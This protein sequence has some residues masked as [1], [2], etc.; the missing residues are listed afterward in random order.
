MSLLYKYYSSSLDLE[1]YLL[2]PTIRLS[3][4]S[5]LNDPF[6]GKLTERLISKLT[7]KM[8]LA[9]QIETTGSDENDRVKMR[10]IIDSIMNSFGVIALTETQ[11]NLLMWAHYASEHRG[12]CIGYQTNLLLNKPLKSE[13]PCFCYNPKKVNYDDVVFDDEQIEAIDRIPYIDDETINN[14]LHRAITTK[15]DEWIYEKEHRIV[16]PIE[17]SD[18]II[19]KNSTKLPD[20]VKNIINKIKDSRGYSINE[21]TKLTTIFPSFKEVR[22]SYNKEEKQSFEN[23]LSKHKE[24]LFLKEIDSKDIKS[25]YLGM[26]YPKAKQNTLIKLL[27]NN[28]EKL[29]HINVYSSDYSKERFDIKTTKIH[30]DSI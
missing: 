4:I 15:S 28:K 5:G 27:K 18:K 12:C 8:I 30:G 25:I 29:G 19:I 11:R 17:W 22:D 26:N 1:N 21:T 9:E 2:N 16:V 20:Y 3:Q 13:S 24:A 23:A 14:V 7:E 6:E 10:N